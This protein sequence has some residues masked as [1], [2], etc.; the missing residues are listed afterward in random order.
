MGENTMLV[1][2]TVAYLKKLIAE[3]VEE[4]LKNKPKKEKKKKADK[5]LTRKQA[6]KL[7]QVSLTTLFHWNNSGEL[8]AQKIGRKVYYH[9]DEIMKKIEL[10]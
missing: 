10:N 2:I 1:Q 4:A 8:L 9:K 7:L 5:L 6:A 3:S